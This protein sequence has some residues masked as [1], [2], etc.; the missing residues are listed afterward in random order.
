VGK[1]EVS[2]EVVRRLVQPDAKFSDVQELVAGTAG[3][4]LLETRDLSKGVFWVGMVQ[5]LIHDIPTCDE[6]IKRIVAD[7]EAI[8]RGRLSGMLAG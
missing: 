4:Q 3:R 8:V 1:S 6:L 2:E 5:G 7:T